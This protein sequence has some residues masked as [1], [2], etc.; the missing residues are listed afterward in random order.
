MWIVHR[1]EI[2][3]LTF[4]ALALRRSDE[5]RLGLPSTLIRHE[6]EGCQKRSANRGSFKKPALRFSVDGKHFKDEAFRIRWR[7]VTMIRTPLHEFTSN[8]N[9]KQWPVIAPI[10]EISPALCER[11]LVQPTNSARVN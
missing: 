5:V 6:K 10:F 11:G 2:R 8:T 7:Y 9:P 1:K 4:R 3:K